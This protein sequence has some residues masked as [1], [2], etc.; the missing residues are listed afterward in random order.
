VEATLE[1]GLPSPALPGPKRK[2]AAALAFNIKWMAETFG[3]EKIGFLTLTCG[4]EKTAEGD[5][6]ISEKKFCGVHERAEAERR[7]N[8]LQTHVISKRYQCGVTVT[9]R[10]KSGAMHFHLVVVCGG[11]LRGTIDHTA[12]FPKKNAAGGYATAPDYSTATT[13]LR[14]EWK[15]WRET[16]ARYGFGRC[17]MQ[18]MKSNGEALGRYVGK[19]ISKS[20]GERRD[21]D[22]GGRL[23]RY[24][25]A[26]SRDGR[27]MGPPMSARHGTTTPRAYAWRAC[28]KMMAALFAGQGVKL[29]EENVRKM[30][31]QHWAFTVT[32]KM[33][34][35]LWPVGGHA[36]MEAGLLE[37]NEQVLARWPMA[38]REDLEAW[39]QAASFFV[40]DD[41][42]LKLALRPGFLERFIDDESFDAVRLWADKQE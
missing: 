38:R 41:P 2:Q 33:N 28:M 5:D 21:D 24:F 1:S 19:Y 36:S 17:Q 29:T 30:M 34:R 7:F 23:V 22:K 32:G 13:R 3:A 27:K 20:W 4:D 6:G 31:G 16:A 35:C 12:C 15:F 8:S 37:H 18:P 10:H 14:L 39:R 42:T 9:E 11:D 40:G 26:W 25:G